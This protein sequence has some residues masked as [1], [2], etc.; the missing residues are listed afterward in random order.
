MVSPALCDLAT[1]GAIPRVTVTVCGEAL[2]AGAAVTVTRSPKTSKSSGYKA[3]FV[4][5]MGPVPVM[6][7]D[8]ADD[9]IPLVNVSS[10]PEP[11]REYSFPAAVNAALSDARPTGGASTGAKSSW[12]VYDV[13]VMFSLTPRM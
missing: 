7:N 6:L 1:L 10:P 13:A 4:D 8:V 9:V 5:N 11:A 12:I 3:E 2:E